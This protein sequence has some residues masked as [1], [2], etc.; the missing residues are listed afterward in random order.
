[1]LHFLFEMVICLLYAA[2]GGASVGMFFVLAFPAPRESA[3]LPSLRATVI[4]A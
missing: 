4:A 1:M 2:V 3:T